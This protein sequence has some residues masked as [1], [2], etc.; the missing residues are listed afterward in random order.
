LLPRP[1][2][3]IENAVVREDPGFSFEPFARVDRIDCDLRWRSLLRSR[4]DCARLFLERPSFNLVRDPHG[5][6][7]VESFLQKN[8]LAAPGPAGGGSTVSLE[9]LDLRVHDARLDFSMG[10]NKKPFALTEMDASLNFDRHTGLLAFRLEGSPIRTDL[11]LPSPGVVRLDGQWTPGADLE[12]P[13]EA[14]LR[15][16]GALLYDWI[17][18]LT[19]HNPQIYGILDTQVHLTGSLHHP[20]LEGEAT[21]SQLHRWEEVPPSDPMPA[22]LFFRGQFDRT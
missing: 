14:S 5:E 21:I 9:N 1:G 2:F 7:N 12:G 4:L 20:R 13:L 18:L 8:G 10:A 6:W 22:T 15:S 11:F 17:P 3:S 16:Q 19:G